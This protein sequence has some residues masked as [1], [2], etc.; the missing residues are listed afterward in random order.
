MYTDGGS[1][2]NPG[3]GGYGVVLLYKGH[4]KEL[5]GGYRRTTNSR[6]ELMAV[7]AGLRTLKTRCAVTLHTD[8]RYVADSIAL[9]W[10]RRW[11][12]NDWR[13]N[14]TEKALNID[15][16]EQILELLDQH[17]VRVLW[18]KGH[19]GHA[20]NERCDQL[21]QQ[22]AQGS[23][24]LVDEGYERRLEQPGRLIE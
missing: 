7:I 4:R 3:P 11:Q 19:A 5:S 2:G 20:E 22:A 1:L 21:T 18:V 13:K 23:N 24:L 12:A 9:G 16:W 10:A 6:M 8:S 17:Q 15:L 14:K